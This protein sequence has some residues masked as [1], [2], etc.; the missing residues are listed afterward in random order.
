M[1][2]TPEVS[3]HTSIKRRIEQA[4]TTQLPNR[5]GQQPGTLIPFAGNPREPMPKGLPFHLS[6]YLELV[7]WSGRSIR[8]NKKGA[9]PEN[10]P[11][12]LNRLNMDASNWLYL[13]GTSKARSSTWSAQPTTS[14]APVK[15]WANAGY[16]A[17]ASA[18]I[19][20]PA[21]SFPFFI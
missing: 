15:R 3:A 5:I 2:K 10:L 16:T 1:A 8:E 11:E 9:I 4:L 21:A 7:D 20:F 19:C 6:D 12:I 14:A 17:S 18:S 13:T